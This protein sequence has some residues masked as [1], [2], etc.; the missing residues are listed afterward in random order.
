MASTP[1]QFELPA[2]PYAYDALEPFVDT[3][4]MHLHHEKHHA[5]YVAKMNEALAANGLHP[6]DVLDV[7][8]LAGEGAGGALLRNNGGG[9]YNHALFWKWM[10]RPG[11]ALSAPPGALK[12]AIEHKW[13]AV[14][15]FRDAFTAAAVGRFGS[16]WAWLGVRPDGTLDVTSTPNQDNP[17]MDGSMIPILGLDRQTVEVNVTPDRGY[18]FSIRGIAREYSHATGAA[19]TDPVV[20]LAAA[21]TSA[22]VNRGPSPPASEAGP[23]NSGSR[24]AAGTLGRLVAVSA[25][26]GR[27]RSMASKASRMTFNGQNRS[28]CAANTNRNRSTSAEVNLR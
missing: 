8:R 15:A 16:G 27:P 19:Y 5:A 2:L 21:A 12:D 14:Q 22:D 23:G 4:T 17:L 1:S 24:L 18:C 11:S 3:T 25:S 7:Q 10:A 28:R 13:G 20:A 9:H 26:T 6:A